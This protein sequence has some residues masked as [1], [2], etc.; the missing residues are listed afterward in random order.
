MLPEAFDPANVCEEQTGLAHSIQK[1][2]T[3]LR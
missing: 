3:F 1:S 2:L